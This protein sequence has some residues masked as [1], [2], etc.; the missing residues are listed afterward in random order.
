MKLDIFLF[1]AMLKVIAPR[2]TNFQISTPALFEMSS[3]VAR[4]TALLLSHYP[5]QLTG[6][7]LTKGELAHTR[8]TSSRF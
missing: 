8:P 3:Y 5:L 6:P 1:T 4:K 2:H 7:K